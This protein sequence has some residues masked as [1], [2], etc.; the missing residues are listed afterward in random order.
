MAKE[1]SRGASNTCIFFHNSCL[2]QHVLEGKH[3]SSRNDMLPHYINISLKESIKKN[4]VG[5]LQS[6]VICAYSEPSRCFL[7]VSAAP[8]TTA[9]NTF[10]YVK[11]HPSERGGM[12]SLASH[13]V[14]FDARN[15]TNDGWFSSTTHSTNHRLVEFRCLNPS[16]EAANG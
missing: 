14:V 4:G 1:M 10:Q 13:S 5:T 6:N 7:T 11:N 16:K 3:P 12:I 15:S 8:F 2:S 9:N